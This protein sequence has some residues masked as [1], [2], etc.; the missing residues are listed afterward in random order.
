MPFVTSAETPYASVGY[1]ECRC[2]SMSVI[3][4]LAVRCHQACAQSILSRNV[5]PRQAHMQLESLLL[6]HKTLPWHGLE[7]RHHVAWA[8]IHTHIHTRIARPERVDSLWHNRIVHLCTGSITGHDSWCCIT[9]WDTSWRGLSS[10]MIFICIMRSL[11]VEGRGNGWLD[12]ITCFC[13]I[14]LYS[15]HRLKQKILWNWSL[16]WLLNLDLEDR[17]LCLKRWIRYQ[18]S[19]SLYIL[20]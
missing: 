4:V 5:A 12:C 7:V 17:N 1:C 11:D 20:I 6:N 16:W 19:F 14:Y 2:P 13:F 3:R 8:D 18:Y 10:G 15:V 9:A